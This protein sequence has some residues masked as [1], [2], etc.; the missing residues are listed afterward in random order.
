MIHNILS[1][2]TLNIDA[3]GNDETRAIM[4]AKQVSMHTALAKFDNHRWIGVLADSLFNL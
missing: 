4:R 3:A 2:T 1:R